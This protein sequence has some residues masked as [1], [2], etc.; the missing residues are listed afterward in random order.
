MYN[1]DQLKAAVEHLLM[2]DVDSVS[3][4][5]VLWDSLEGYSELSDAEQEEVYIRAFEL[6]D[7]AEVSV[8]WPDD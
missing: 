8:T 3:V 1:D 2:P 7:A 6:I 5:E 4:A